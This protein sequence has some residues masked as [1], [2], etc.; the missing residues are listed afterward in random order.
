MKASPGLL[1]VIGQLASA[2]LDEGIVATANLLAPLLLELPRA[3]PSAPAHLIAGG[4]LAEQLQAVSSI[5]AQLGMRERER[6]SGGEWAA[7]WLS[8][9]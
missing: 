2:D 3:L 1:P 8:L 4:L 5:A 7:I 6:R 9:T